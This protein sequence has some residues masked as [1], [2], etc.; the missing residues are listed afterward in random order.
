MATK[1]VTPTSRN[2]TAHREQKGNLQIEDDEQDGDEVVADI[3]LH[4]RVLE[5]LEATLVG[6]ILLR[7]GVPQ[8]GTKPKVS[9]TAPKNER[10][11]D[12]D[13]YGYIFREHG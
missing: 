8:P 13:Q 11:D 10:D 7:I 4:A 6:R 12:E 3:E 9:A 2:A 1:P 5:G